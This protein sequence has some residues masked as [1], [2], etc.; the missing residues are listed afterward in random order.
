MLDVRSVR[1]WELRPFPRLTFIARRRRSLDSRSHLTSLVRSHAIA[2][3]IKC[4]IGRSDGFG[5]A[6]RRGL[7]LAKAFVIQDSEFTLHHDHLGGREAR[8]E[9][10]EAIL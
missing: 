5:G 4:M 6:V 7:T 8:G 3:Q 2:Q 10:I 9:R 1:F